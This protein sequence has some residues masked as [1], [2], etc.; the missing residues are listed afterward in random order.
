MREMSV[1]W[2][3]MSSFG[4]NGD[5]FLELSPEWGCSCGRDLLWDLL[6]N[7]SVLYAGVLV[8]HKL[9]LDRLV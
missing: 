8:D 2:D 4:M 9:T 6:W 1:W 5:A 3:F 7:L